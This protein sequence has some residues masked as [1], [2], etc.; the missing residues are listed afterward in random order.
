MPCNNPP[1]ICLFFSAWS[2]RGT[3]AKAPFHRPPSL[4]P[5]EFR[6]PPRDTHP[7]SQKVGAPT[8]RDKLYTNPI[9]ALWSWPFPT[10]LPAPPLSRL[11]PYPTSCGTTGAST[12]DS[13]LSLWRVCEQNFF[14]DSTNDDTTGPHSSMDTSE[15]SPPLEA[16]AP[17]AAQTPSALPEK[18]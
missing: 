4:L 18:S 5:S 11:S 2:R 3:N 1:I 17:D 12:K 14:H 15:S 16:S 7:H 9:C 10:V 13:P 6:I 8:S